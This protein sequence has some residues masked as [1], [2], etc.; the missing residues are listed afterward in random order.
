[1]PRAHIGSGAKIRNA[2][3]AEKAVVSPHALIGYDTQGEWPQF[4]V[5]DNGVAIVC[6]TEP[7]RQSVPCSPEFLDQ[8]RNEAANNLRGNPEFPVS[9]RSSVIEDR[10]GLVE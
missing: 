10:F 7:S 3:V 8:F 5:T 9:E 2:I 1:V 4:P 6:A